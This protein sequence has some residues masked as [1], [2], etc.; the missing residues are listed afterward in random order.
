MAA[1]AFNL[2]KPL[3]LRALVKLF[4]DRLTIFIAIFCLVPTRMLLRTLLH[5]H[6]HLC[7]NASTNAIPGEHISQEDFGFVC[8][9]DPPTHSTGAPLGEASMAPRTPVHRQPTSETADLSDTVTD[10]R[11]PAA[12]LSW[13]FRQ[14][15]MATDN[16][17]K[18][19]V[20]CMVH[21]VFVPLYCKDFSAHR[22]RRCRAF[23]QDGMRTSASS[24]G[25]TGGGV[26][27]V[28][29]ESDQE[30]ACSSL[31]TGSAND[32][33]IVTRE[34]ATATQA[35][36]KLQTL[37]RKNAVLMHEAHQ[38]FTSQCVLLHFVPGIAQ[39]AEEVHNHLHSLHSLQ[40]ETVLDRVFT[41][42]QPSLV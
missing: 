41:S 15:A 13:I 38:S 37:C 33:D 29:A 8:L 32:F 36:E 4:E 23:P 31:C 19:A 28:F 16:V 42:S 7:N 39:T 30:A 35:V 21:P 2:L 10:A 22:L 9:V 40:C 1:R 14:S 3:K 6:S 26:P 18:S 5:R 20:S 24:T 27:A 11:S 25:Y 17:I 12:A 34:L